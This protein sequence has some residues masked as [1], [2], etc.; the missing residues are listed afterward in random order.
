MPTNTG[1]LGASL[2]DSG[3]PGVVRDPTTK[4]DRARA[5]FDHG[6]TKM[7]KTGLKIELS[8]ILRDWSMLIKE[9]SVDERE[10]PKGL[11]TGGEGKGAQY[12]ELNRYIVEAAFRVM[13]FEGKC[14]AKEATALKE[15][16]HIVTKG[17][18]LDNM[19]RIADYGYH[20]GAGDR[21]RFEELGRNILEIAKQKYKELG[22]EF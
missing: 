2:G 14:G 9:G 8:P 16:I 4:P 10:G 11:S 21:E 6:D 22:I 12:G 7:K 17:K 1:W 18:L 5:K 15:H 3:G 20:L 19:G 13:W